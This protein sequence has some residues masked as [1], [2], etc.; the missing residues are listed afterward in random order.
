MFFPK[1]RKP[2]IVFLP[3]CFQV[4]T[5]FLRLGKLESIPG[6]ITISIVKCH[7]LS[8][9]LRRWTTSFQWSHLRSLF[10]AVAEVTPCE[11]DRV[12]TR[13]VGSMAEVSYNDARELINIP[14]LKERR[15]ILCE[16]FF[17]RDENLQKLDEFLPNKSSSVYDTRGNCKYNN[18]Y[19]KTERF[20]KS[21]LPQ[22]ISKLNCK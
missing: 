22:I 13:L 4:A 18:Y 3:Q 11:T 10:R 20:R 19:C 1:V 9:L 12:Q 6:N 21:F 17:L 8:H 15:E 2:E 14:S 7:T 5:M 16:Q